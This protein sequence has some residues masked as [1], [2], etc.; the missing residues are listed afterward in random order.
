[1][2]TGAISEQPRLLILNPVLCP[3]VCE[4]SAGCV[5][6]ASFSRHCCASQTLRSARA[7]NRGRGY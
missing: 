1:M 5:R 4:S 7:L 3:G 2:G 6:Q